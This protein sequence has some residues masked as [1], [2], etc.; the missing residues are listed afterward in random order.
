MAS[1]DQ[2]SPS[3]SPP[4]LVTCPAGTVVLR[5]ERLV[6]DTH[7][8]GGRRVFVGRIGPADLLTL[9]RSLEPGRYR[10]SCL[11]AQGRFLQDGAHAI[12]ILERGAEPRVVSARTS[13]DYPAVRSP[14]VTARRKEREARGRLNLQRQRMRALLRKL[15]IQ[16]RNDSTRAAEHL[17]TRHRDVTSQDHLRA[18]VDLLSQQVADAHATIAQIASR[19][20]EMQARVDQVISQHATKEQQVAALGVVVTQLVSILRP[21]TSALAHAANDGVAPNETADSSGSNTVGPPLVHVSNDPRAR[22]HAPSMQPSVATVTTPPVDVPSRPSW[23][24]TTPPDTSE[25][26]RQFLKHPTKRRP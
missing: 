10:V 7:Q 16:R 2:S 3:Q 17:K 5:V 12:E 21:L 26:L 9:L 11:N 24:Q 4:P 18:R 25:Q 13:R 1:I 19:D 23:T 14:L 15:A 22:A 8:R 20:R 6:A